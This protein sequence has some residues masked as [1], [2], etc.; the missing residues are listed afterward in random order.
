MT[1]AA[2]EYPEVFAKARADIDRVCGMCKDARL[3]NLDDMDALPYICA[4]CK[5]VLRWPLIFPLTPEHT[6]SQDIEFEGYYFPAGTGF[7]INEV[8]VLLPCPMSAS[9]LSASCRSGGWTATR[10]TLRT[11][12][13]SLAEAGGSASAIGWRSEACS[14]TWPGWCSASTTSRLVSSSPTLPCSLIHV[15][16]SVPFAFVPRL[17]PALC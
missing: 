6:A 7:T 4:M 8:A 5:D 12:C 13:G 10:R 3:P 9:I 14:S 16:S 15:F 2:L 11:G 1:M 17:G